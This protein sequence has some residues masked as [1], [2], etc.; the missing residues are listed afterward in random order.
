M[1]KF[2]GK[3][4]MST[5]EERDIPI[6]DANG[7]PTT[8]VKRHRFTKIQLLVNDPDQKL[9]RVILCTSVD[10][11]PT[12]QVPKNGATWETPEVRKYDVKQGVPEVSF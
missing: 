12:F 8:Q 2:S 9:E 1:L 6:K 11:P 7:I 5:D 3:V 4:M 10:L